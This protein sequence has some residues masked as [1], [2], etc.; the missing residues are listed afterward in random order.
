MLFAGKS[1]LQVKMNALNITN[2]AQVGPFLQIYGHKDRNLLN[3][4]NNNIQ[5]YLPRLIET[6]PVAQQFDPNQVYLVHNPRSNKYFRCTF[7]DQRQPDRVTVE[8]ID[9]G[10][11]FDVLAQN[12]SLIVIV[13]VSV[14]IFIFTCVCVRERMSLVARRHFSA[15]H[16][17]RSVSW[18][19]ECC[20]NWTV[21]PLSGVIFIIFVVSIFDFR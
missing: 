11:E 5:L 16:E 12:V 17:I 21:A 7:I 10:N 19:A 9:Y 3:S 18:S 13:T 15:S 20:E 2:V 4:L 1:R 14:F 8:F 6:A